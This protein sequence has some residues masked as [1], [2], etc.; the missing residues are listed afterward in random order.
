[1]PKVPKTKEKMIQTVLNFPVKKVPKKQP[2]QPNHAP[3]DDKIVPIPDG[4]FDTNPT[5]KKVLKTTADNAS[6]TIP[7]KKSKTKSIP[8]SIFNNTPFANDKD[9]THDNDVVKIPSGMF[10]TDPISDI[11][12]VPSTTNTTR[13]SLIKVN[14]Q[15]NQPRLFC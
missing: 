4:M 7:I 13:D 12:V 14:Q 5:T 2:Q 1:M 3:N 6:S 15:Q 11:V 10:D 8:Q 9:S